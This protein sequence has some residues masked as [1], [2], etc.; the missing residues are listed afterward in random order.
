M[1]QQTSRELLKAWSMEHREKTKKF[2]WIPD[3]RL[4][5]IPE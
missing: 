3:I 2:I 5:Q 4:R 1:K